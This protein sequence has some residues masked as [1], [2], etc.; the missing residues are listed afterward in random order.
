MET[1]TVTEVSLPLSVT[2]VVLGI[3]ILTLAL[4]IV[5]AILRKAG[6][7]GKAKPPSS[8][9]LHE[10]S[11][12]HLMSRFDEVLDEL[13]ELKQENEIAKETRRRDS[14]ELRKIRSSV[15]ILSH[16]IIAARKKDK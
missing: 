11:F 3:F 14:N 1:E 2:E 10:K 13:K 15:S 7:M 6:L 8:V 16:W 9:M 12:G 5:A 4:I